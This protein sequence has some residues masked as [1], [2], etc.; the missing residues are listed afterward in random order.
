MSL[1]FAPEGH[2]YRW[3]GTVVPSVTQVIDGY[4]RDYAG[5][6]REILKR[7][8]ELGNLVHEATALDAEGRLDEDSIDDEVA[9]YIKAWR[10][11][12]AESKAEIL[13]SERPMYHPLYGYAGTPDHGVIINGCT[14]ILDKKTGVPSEADVVQ[15]AAYYAMAHHNDPRGLKLTMA[16]RWALYL[17]K[18]GTYKLVRHDQPGMGA[19]AMQTF[20]ACLSI[21]KWRQKRNVLNLLPGVTV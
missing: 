1:T 4:L 6:P 11:F 5:I 20:L 10:K 8:A 19:E 15:T 12:L 14:G 18:N 16:N 7:A 17:R 21:A 9:P 2:T 13:W 3:S